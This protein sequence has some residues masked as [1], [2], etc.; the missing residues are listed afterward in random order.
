M[1]G[2]MRLLNWSWILDV[3]F[4]YIYIFPF[5]FYGPIVHEII[6]TLKGLSESPPWVISQIIDD[7]RLILSNFVS[8]SVNFE[9]S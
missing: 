2:H 3:M 9:A 1:V 7:I 4:I 8:C 5:K 6:I